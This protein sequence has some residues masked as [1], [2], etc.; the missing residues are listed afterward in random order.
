M[1]Q[2]EAAGALGVSQKT[3]QRWAKDG[4]LVPSRI[5]SRI[6]LYSVEQLE[7]FL[8]RHSTDRRVG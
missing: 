1:N 2:K 7:G 4:T 8:R 6:T 3:L 5:G